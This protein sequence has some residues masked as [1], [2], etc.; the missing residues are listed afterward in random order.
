MNALNLRVGRNFVLGP[1]RLDV[2]I[3]IFNLLNGATDQQFFDGGNQ[4]YSSNYA[5]KPNRSFFGVNRQPPR[6]GQLTVRVI[7]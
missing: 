2:A 4:I 7:F 3:D 1:L 5:P 6:A